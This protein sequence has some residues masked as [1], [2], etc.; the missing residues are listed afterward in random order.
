M[1]DLHGYVAAPRGTPGLAGV[2]ADA[3]T[4]DA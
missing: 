2:A 4:L 3:A 1:N